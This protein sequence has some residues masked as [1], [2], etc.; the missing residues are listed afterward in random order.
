MNIIECIQESLVLHQEIGA[1]T[2]SKLE[3]IK[4]QHFVKSQQH[5]KG[6]KGNIF[7]RVQNH[8]ADQLAGA[9][10]FPRRSKERSHFIKSA[11]KL[12]AQRNTVQ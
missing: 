12:K 10:E 2:I 4:S 7:H 5:P 8:R 3:K 9:A 11:Q 6:S 1:G